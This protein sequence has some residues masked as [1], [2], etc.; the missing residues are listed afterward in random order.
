VGVAAAANAS[1]VAATLDDGKVVLL[2]EVSGAV[3]KIASLPAPGARIIDVSP[4]GRMVATLSGPDPFGSA[5]SDTGIVLW[6][7]D[8]RRLR[9]VAQQNGP[10]RRR[11]V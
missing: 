1:T 8:G 2:D 11:D 7:T 3:R 4:G 10:D 5:G 9:T 6:S